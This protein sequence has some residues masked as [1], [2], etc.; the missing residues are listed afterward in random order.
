MFRSFRI[1]IIAAALSTAAIAGWTSR[2]WYQSH[3]DEQQ[4]EIEEAF[5]QG[6]SKIALRVEAKLDGLKQN[7]RVIERH[8]R[9]IV[10]RE[11]YRVE[12]IDDDGLRI[13]E[14]YAAGGTGQF[15]E[16]L[17]QNTAR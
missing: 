4:R 15:V 17:P 16:T 10:K 13:I 3:I 8:T 9:E 6:E 11:T 5:R 2:D 12:C 1:Y 14:A 7:E